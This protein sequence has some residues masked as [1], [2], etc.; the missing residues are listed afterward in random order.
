MSD[1]EFDPQDATLAA[2]LSDSGSDNPENQDATGLDVHE[3]QDPSGSHDAED[4]RGNGRGRGRGNGRGRGRGNGRGRGR[5]NGRGRGRGNGRGRGRGNGRGR[6][7]V[8]GTAQQVIRSS[9]SYLDADT[10]NDSPI[11][12]QTRAPGLYM[13]RV[14]RGSMTKAIDFFQLFFT[15]ELI[16][17]ICTHSNAYAWINKT[18]KQSYANTQGAWNETSY[19]E[20]KK[21]IGLLIY[22]GLT[23]VNSYD[24]YWNTKTLYHGL[25]ARS[26]MPRKR[27]QALMAMLHIVDPT[28]ERQRRQI[29]KGERIS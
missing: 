7:R 2:T 23:K 17:E 12:Q 19:E 6:G 3:G 1:V 5:G 29:A 4:G 26:F 20:L 27:F 10:P 21:L 22:F 28:R 13:S 16:N 15:V 24:R 9:K 14:T 25:W 18:N 8:N 11:F